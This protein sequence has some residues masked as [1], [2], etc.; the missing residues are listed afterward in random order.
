VLQPTQDCCCHRI[1]IISDGPD[2]ERLSA[3]V[4]ELASSR[5]FQVQLQNLEIFDFLDASI[6]TRLSE[7]G[8]EYTVRTYTPM[9]GADSKG[10]RKEAYEARIAQFF[11]VFVQY[12]AAFP[13]NAEGVVLLPSRADASANRTFDS[14]EQQ[15]AFDNLVKYYRALTPVPSVEAPS[16][17][18]NR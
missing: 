9:G 8:R 14:A 12:M 2:D 7:C 13:P 10:P 17:P 15:R 5:I 11:A 16:R 1:E 4:S 18:A 6:S 3:V